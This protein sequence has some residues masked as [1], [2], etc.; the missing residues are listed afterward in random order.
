MIGQRLQYIAS[1]Q[2]RNASEGRGRPP[3]TAAGLAYLR[4]AVSKASCGKS[5]WS[6]AA[7]AAAAAAAE[8][9]F[10]FFVMI[11]IDRLFYQ[12]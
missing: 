12:R 4:K 10:F 5:P 11:S 3:A 8:L 6:I 1:M 9:D 2:A 7:W